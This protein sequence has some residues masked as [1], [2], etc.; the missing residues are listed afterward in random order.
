MSIIPPGA[1]AVQAEGQYKHSHVSLDV[2][3][4]RQRLQC[5]ESFMRGL[6]TSVNI[7]RETSSDSGSLLLSTRTHFGPIHL[8][9]V[10]L[11]WVSTSHLK[12]TILT[13]AYTNCCLDS[14]SYCTRSSIEEISRITRSTDPVSWDHDRPRL[15]RVSPLP[16]AS[17]HQAAATTHQTKEGHIHHN[18]PLPSRPFDVHAP[19]GSIMTFRQRSPA[20][21]IP[22]KDSSTSLASSYHSSS[23]RHSTRIVN[24]E[25]AEAVR[26]SV[27]IGSRDGSNPDSPNIDF[28]SSTGTRLPNPPSL[29]PLIPRRTPSPRIPP[30]EDNLPSTKTTNRMSYLQPQLPSQRIITSQNPFESDELEPPLPVQQT[31][32]RAVHGNDGDIMGQSVYAR[33]K[34]ARAQTGLTG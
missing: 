28:S 13:A 19:L 9:I 26:D 21:P 6:L 25:L 32:I 29:N 22:P 18:R 15:R 2:S 30:P 3:A 7:L 8:R 4:T 11:S 20:P 17:T 12:G 16:F 23:S 27:H 33:T 14:D 5:R 10:L 34:L 24:T 31:T 1:S